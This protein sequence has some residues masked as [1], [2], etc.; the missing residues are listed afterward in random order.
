[1]LAGVSPISRVHCH[2][3]KL[4]DQKIQDMEK[5][6]YVLRERTIDGVKEEAFYRKVDVSV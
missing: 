6:G 2:R 3:D 4:K 1:M 5:K